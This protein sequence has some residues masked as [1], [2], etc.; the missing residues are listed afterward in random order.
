MIIE[1][2]YNG[3]ADS[4]NGGWSA[5]LVA[6][7]LGGGDA[8]V[9]LRVPPPLATPMSVAREDGTVRVYAPDGTL[10]ASATATTVD[11][12]ADLV[13]PASFAE[14]LAAQPSYPG[15]VTHPFP[16]CFGCG[17]RRA[18][19][20]GMRLFAGRLPD[21]RTAS[22]W[23]VPGDVS[24]T[25]IWAALDCTGGWAVGVEARP[26]VLGR[27]AAHVARVPE[28]GS[29]CVVVGRLLGTEGRKARVATAVYDGG[30]TP[31]GYARAT[32]IAIG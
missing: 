21:G 11:P 27:I 9:T 10:V 22:A 16:T 13:P 28:P 18:E 1:P 17:T 23:R 6:A 2:R 31:I 19:G 14:A 26:Y 4:G 3:P 8:E 15:F 7:A 25:M 30:A 32:W 12:V 20:D 24:P 29:E 5:G